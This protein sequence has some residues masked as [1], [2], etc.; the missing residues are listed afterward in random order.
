MEANT[1]NQTFEQAMVRL[2]QIAELLE[3]QQGTLEESLKLFEEANQ[4]ALFCEESLDQAERK[5]Q[6]LSKR[7]DGFHLRPESV[8]EED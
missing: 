1:N 8:A 5:L 7:E 6:I 2:E 3:T 4:L